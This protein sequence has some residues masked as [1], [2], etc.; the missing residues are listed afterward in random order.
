MRTYPRET[1]PKLVNLTVIRERKRRRRLGLD[2]DTGLP[3]VLQSPSEPPELPKSP[4]SGS[5]PLGDVVDGIVVKDSDQGQ[6]PGLGVLPGM[7]PEP[8]SVPGPESPTASPGGQELD[9][10]VQIDPAAALEDPSEQLRS[11]GV[12]LSPEA[13]SETLFGSESSDSGR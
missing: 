4:A 7:D 8:G 10:G 2:P 9:S 3:P 13:D 1:D 6:E 12:D 11:P 5:S